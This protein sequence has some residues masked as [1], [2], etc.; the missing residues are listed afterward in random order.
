MANP[1]D[2]LHFRQAYGALLRRDRG[3]EHAFRV[4]PLRDDMT[5]TQAANMV[6]AVRRHMVGIVDFGET[7]YVSREITDLLRDAAEQLSMTLFHFEPDDFPSLTGTVYFDGAVP[8]P[9]HLDPSGSQ[10]LR[11][12]LWGQFTNPK[13]PHHGEHGSSFQL[14]GIDRNNTPHNIDGKILYSIVDTPEAHRQQMGPWM[15]RHW[16]PLGYGIR[17]STEQIRN[18]G[19]EDRRFRDQGLTD[20]EVEMDDQDA[21]RSA[22]LIYRLLYVWTNFL[23][24]EIAGHRTLD[25]DRLHKK[26]AR[27]EGRPLPQVRIVVLRRYASG[28][29]LGEGEAPEWTH[30]WKVRGHWRQQRVGPGRAFIRPTFIPEYTK[31]PAHLPLDERDTIQAIVR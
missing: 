27:R 10:P 11:A 28:P 23:K 2:A 5:D 16:M 30:R 8:L 13:D 14:S 20:A 6:E 4:A 26:M 7:F 31:G 29:V 12:L 19:N 18:H 3:F 24:T 15:P 22:G 17:Y 1:L 9:T 25:L 21:R